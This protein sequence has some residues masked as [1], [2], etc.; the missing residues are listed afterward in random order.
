VAD[1][2]LDAFVV[3]AVL[4]GRTPAGTIDPC[5][6]FPGVAHD[7]VRFLDVGAGESWDDFVAWAVGY[8]FGGL[9]CLS[10]IPGTVGGTPI[11]NVGAY[12]QEVSAL[13]ERVRVLDRTTGDMAWMPAADCAFRYRESRFNTTERDRWIVLAVTFALPL[14]APPCLDYRDVAE[15]FAG[16]TAPPTRAAVRDA[17]LRIR[18]AKG[19]VLDAGDPDSRSAGSFFKNPVIAESAYP[20]LAEAAGGALPKFAADPGRVKVPAARLIEAAGFARGY[21]RGGAAI[22]TKHTLALTNRG[23]ATAADVVALARDIREGVRERFGVNLTPEPILA[24]FDDDA[25]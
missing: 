10:G 3:R 9:E 4:A 6:R 11:Q 13:I 8:D 23:G 18:R 15:V 24:G 17:V 14:G 16:A 5:L 22:S 12:G 20:A 19:M 1:A 2:G 25:L 21:A 7:Q